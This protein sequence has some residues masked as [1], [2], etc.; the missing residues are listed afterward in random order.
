VRFLTDPVLGKRVAHLRRRWSVPS[1]APGPIDAVLIS[2]L[3]HD[4]L[5]LASLRLLGSIPMIVP[6]G[7][8]R[9]IGRTGHDNVV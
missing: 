2:H 5:D 8:G 4:Y 3:H 6:R 7:A 9:L 1:L